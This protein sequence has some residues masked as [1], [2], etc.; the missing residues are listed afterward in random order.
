MVSGPHRAA[1]VLGGLLCAG[2]CGEDPSAFERLLEQEESAAASFCAR[3]D[4]CW[5]RDSDE[6][7][8]AP[9]GLT[10]TSAFRTPFTARLVNCLQGV[11]SKHTAAFA[12]QSR[13]YTNFMDEVSECIRSCPA[14]PSVATRHRSTQRRASG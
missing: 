14:D 3:A 11:N 10:P 8:T 9:V 1:L 4:Q 6:L 12:T 2:G 5:G 13:C 7:C